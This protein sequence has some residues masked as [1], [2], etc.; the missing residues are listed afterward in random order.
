M[1]DL[2]PSLGPITWENA[3]PQESEAVG[4]VVGEVRFWEDG[5]G[6]PFRL[7]NERFYRQYRGFER[8]RAAWREG[9]GRDRDAMIYDAEK[10]WG[11]QLHIP[12]SY[13]TIERL[14]PKAIAQMPRLLYSARD[15]QWRK[16]VETVRLLID[17]QQANISIDLPLQAVM[18][19][20][21]IYGLGAGKTYW[22]TE[23]KSRRRMEQHRILSSTRHVLGPSKLETTFDDPMFEDI[24]IFDLMWDPAGSDVRSCAWMVHRRWM[25]TEEVLQRVQSGAWATDSA[26]KLDSE[27]KIRSLGADQRRYGEVWAGRMQA[28]G[29]DAFNLNRQGEHPHELLEWH[30]GERVWSVLDRQVLVQDGENPCGDMPFQ[31]YRPTPVNKELVGIGWLEPLEHLQR[32][33]DTLRS[34]RRD[35]ATIAL[36][37]GYA[38]DEAAVDPEDLVFSPGMAIPVSNANPKEALFPLP[39]N[40]VPGSSYQ[41][42]QAIRA[43]MASASGESDTMEAPVGASSTATEAQLV[44]ASLSRRIELC[45]RR[46]E[47]EVVRPIAVNFLYLDQRMIT[48]NRAALRVPQEGMTPEEADELGA[49]RE[50][51]V[52]PG[53][54][55][56]EYEIEP[57]GG[58]MA[59]RNIPQDRADAAFILQNL[60]H[61]WYI[62]PTKARLRA[63]E[64][65]DIKHPV[66]WLRDPTPMAP[67]IA[68]R[69][70]IEAGVDTNLVAE[71]VI[72][73]RE[74]SAP[75]EGPA[76][77]QITEQVPMEGSQ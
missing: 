30:D 16:N 3:S 15:E 58:S 60:A 44:Q 11:A 35:A 52:G 33:L 51:P 65:L 40:E 53:E 24:D 64:L 29:F 22:R 41:E 69:Y 66:G 46:F 21:G 34:Q 42:E 55:L 4:R 26:K 10:E 36:N 25:S 14:V 6:R 50:Y 54:L 31:I 2:P 37:A 9:T 71:A 1:T 23:V 49:W 61:D 63:M 47:T 12:L 17:R 67:M 32:E 74:T 8:F 20:G 39:V 45:S 38:F 76:A 19:S 72:R 27:E 13:S 77:S 28:T 48:E 43:D 18:R 59:A 62:N 73:A 70:L 68:F 57:E 7:R 5:I 75:Q 56:G